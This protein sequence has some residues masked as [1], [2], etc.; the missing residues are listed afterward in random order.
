M[1][2]SDFEQLLDLY[3]ATVIWQQA[4]PCPCTLDTG[5]AN[6][7]CLICSGTSRYHSA[8]SAPFEVALLNQSARDRMAMA[9]TM[10]PGALGD[11]TLVVFSGAPCYAEVAGGDRFWDTMRVERRRLILQPGVSLAL[12]PLTANLQAAVKATD[13]AS[14]VLVDPPVPDANRRVSVSVVTRLEFD[15][16][17]GYEVV[18]DLTRVRTFGQ[19]LPKQFKVRLLDVSV[20]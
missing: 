13:G 18:A 16:P 1:D 15:A 14:L 19:N 7:Q 3:A 5:A 8:L 9:Q 11:G 4:F 2:G 17:R 6:R 10:G 12:P 20:R